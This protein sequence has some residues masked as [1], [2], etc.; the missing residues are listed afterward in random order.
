MPK[1]FPEERKMYHER[2]RLS[3]VVVVVVAAKR[4]NTSLPGRELV[5]VEYT[6]YI[7]VY[8]TCI[9]PSPFHQRISWRWKLMTTPS[10]FIYLIHGISVQ[11]VIAGARSPNRARL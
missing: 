10:L 5:H 8:Y 7:R 1:A 6:M 2:E 3:V 11:R 9:P 4:S